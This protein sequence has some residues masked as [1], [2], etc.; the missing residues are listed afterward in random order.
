MPPTAAWSSTAQRS[1]PASPSERAAEAGHYARWFRT[2]GIRQVHQTTGVQ[3][4]EGDF[5]VVGDRILAGTGFRTHPDTHAEI[6]ALTGL[7]VIT[8]DLVD[9]RFYHLDTALG[10]LDERTIAYYPPAFSAASRRLLAELHPDAIIATD[11]DAQVLGLNLVSDGRHVVMTDAAPHLE[12]QIR[13]AG[14]EPITLDLSELLKGGGGIKCCTL[15]LRPAA[16]AGQSASE[17]LMTGPNTIGAPR[18]LESSPEPHVAHNYSPLP[19]VAA[20]A[21]ARGSPTS[22]DTGISIVS[23]L[24]R[25]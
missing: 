21:E 13:R 2:A 20:T 22:T 23:A 9:P 6:A 10:V 17:A 25:Q 7:P 1:R 14:F 11:A 19:V 18:H 8:L 24:T 3:E 15:E 5:L 12:S 16:D 4:G